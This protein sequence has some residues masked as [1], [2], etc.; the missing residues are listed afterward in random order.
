M[1]AEMEELK[2]YG[3]LSNLIVVDLNRPDELKHIIQYLSQGH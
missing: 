3:K 1:R 2:N